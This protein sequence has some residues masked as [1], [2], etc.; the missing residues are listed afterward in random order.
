[1]GLSADWIATVN[2]GLT[3]VAWDDYDTLVQAEV[4]PLVCMAKPVAYNPRFILDGSTGYTGVDW[5]LVKAM[6]W[7]ES[8][9]KSPAWKTRPMQFGNDGDPGLEVLK[10]GREGS[11]VVMDPSLAKAIKSE[12]I[13]TPKLNIRAGM[14]YL[15][16]RMAKFTVRSVIDKNDA[17]IRSE[18]VG[19]GDNLWIIAKRV[20]TTVDELTLQRQLVS[21]AVNRVGEVLKYRPAA[22]KQ[23]IVAWRDWTTSNIAD[24]YNSGGDADYQ[25]KLDYVLQLFPKLKR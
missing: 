20:G 10:A 17:S 12:S 19:N 7:V 5:L 1:M 22:M 25:A 9:A 2:D 6:M 18:K 8:G 15:F 13:D 23:V 11:D 24:R 4:G 3:N 21:S 16:T 14:A